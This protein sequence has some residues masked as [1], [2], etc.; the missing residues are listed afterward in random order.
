MTADLTML[1][2]RDCGVC[3]HV[4]RVLARLD[5]RGRLQLVSLQA[6]ERP[7]LP[8]RA[9]LLALLH[10]VDASGHYSVGGAAIVEIAR[11]IPLLW[12][13]SVTAKLPLAMAL[14][15]LFARTVANHRRG[16]S[17]LLGLQTCQVRSA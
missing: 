3:T 16:I 11:R 4:A 7:D 17:R 14:L 13:I 9:E 8:P 10:V 5:S 2:D 15:D 1:Y 6:A 12:P